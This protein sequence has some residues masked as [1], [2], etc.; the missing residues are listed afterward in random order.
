MLGPTCQPLYELNVSMLGPTCKPLF[1]L[2]VCI[3]VGL[4]FG[5]SPPSLTLATLLDTAAV[6]LGPGYQPE[7]TKM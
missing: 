2:N 3:Y 4:F 7:S 6:Y 1:E 5:S